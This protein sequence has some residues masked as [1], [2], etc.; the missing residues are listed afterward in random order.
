[1]NGARGV[2]LSR[3]RSWSFL[4]YTPLGLV[5]GATR[6]TALTD[7]PRGTLQGACCAIA[8]GHGSRSG[9]LTRYKLHSQD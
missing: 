3:W 8:Q 6:A 7:A 4:P 2:G 1:M 5:T 9:H